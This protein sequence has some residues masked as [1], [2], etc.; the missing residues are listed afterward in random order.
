MKFVAFSL[1]FFFFISC[2]TRNKNNDEQ[3]VEQMLVEDTIQTVEVDT[4]TM[5]PFKQ[6]L[7]SNGKLASKEMVGVQ[8][9]TSQKISHIYVKNG[10]YVKKGQVIASLE[11]FTF[12]NKLQQAQ[13]DLKRSKLELQDQ[14]IGQGFKLNDTLNVPK[15]TLDLL[16]VKSGY[17]RALNQYE[18]AQFDYKNSVLYA[19]INGVIA[20]LTSKTNTFPDLSKDFCNIVNLHKMETIFPVLESELSLIKK[21]DLVTINPFSMPNVKIKGQVSEINPWVNENGMV[22][23]KASAE[24]HPKMIEGMGV[25]VHIFRELEKQWVVPKTAVVLRN[26]REVVFSVKAGKA[27]WNYIEVGQENAI[28]YTI[29]S[30]SLKDGDLIITKG[31]INLAH[32]S[33][34]KIKLNTETE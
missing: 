21:G 26:N 12:K 10:D 15:S 18:M 23:I 25:R 17:N 28:Q 16:K 29:T 11:K 9:R 2:N 8:F 20:N 33:P 32:E 30:E 22:L 34:I 24:Y 27:Y 13:D 31:N 3:S 4:L 1:L 7:I 14:L 19:P 5:R 6:E